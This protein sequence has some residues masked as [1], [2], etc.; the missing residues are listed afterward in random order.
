MASRLE[1]RLL[2]V[3]CQDETGGTNFGSDDIA[4][5]GVAVNP[6]GST[7]KIG[8]FKIGEFDKGES[9]PVDRRLALFDL[10]NGG[11]FPKAFAVTL[12]LAEKDHGGLT[13]LLD[14]LPKQI[15]D[16]VI[17]S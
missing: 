5:G 6:D 12:V 3:K 7:A 10:R 1:F 8:E 17:E 9:K 14:R 4:V 13:K 2:R 11:G 16:H 15:S